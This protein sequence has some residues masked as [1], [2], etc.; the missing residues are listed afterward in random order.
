MSKEDI[1]KTIAERIKSEYSKHKE[2]DW[3]EIAAIKIYST[4]NIKSKQR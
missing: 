2:L 3:A 4:F 1:I